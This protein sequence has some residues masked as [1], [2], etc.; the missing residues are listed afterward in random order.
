MNGATRPSSGL[1]RSVISYL[2]DAADYPYCALTSVKQMHGSDIIEIVVEPELDQ[3]RKI[4]ILH[5]EPVRV[6]FRSPDDKLSPIIVSMRK[7]FP[8]GHVHTSLERGID[9]PGLCI[10]EDNWHDLSSVM[11]GQV[12]IE[13]IRSWFTRM[14]IGNL[15]DTEQPAEPLI[16]SSAHT[17]VLPSGPF[18]DKLHLVAAHETAGVFTVFAGLNPPKNDNGIPQ[19]SLFKLTTEPQIHRAIAG[20]PS[21]LG[22]LEARLDEM[23]VDCK[24][25]LA[26]W[27]KHP[28]QMAVASTNCVLFIIAIPMRKA[29]GGDIDS[30]E[31]WAFTSDA[32]IAE[33]GTDLG[34]T[35]TSEASGTMR[36]TALLL[37]SPGTMPNVALDN[38]RVV[39]RLDRNAAR[40]FSGIQSSTDLELLAI[41][42]GAI[43]S[44]VVLGAAKSGLGRWTIVDGDIVLPH[45]T[46]RQVQDDQGIGFSKAD[47]LAYQANSL[48]AEAGHSSIIAD[49]LAPEENFADL[50]AA[51]QTADLAVDFSASPAVLGWM[52]D[53]PLKRAVSFFFGPDGRDLVLL[54][55]DGARQI[56]LDAIESQYFAA[57]ASDERLAGHLSAARVDKIR[58]ANACQDITRPL[59]TWQVQM[60]SALASGQLLELTKTADPSARIWR[61]D[62]ASGAV[63]VISISVAPI[64]RIVGQDWDI[65]VAEKVLHTICGLRGEALPDETGG[66]LLGTFDMVRRV[67]HVVEILPAP[68]DSRQ[69]PTHFVRG[70]KDLLPRIEAMAVNTAGRLSYIGEW[71]SHPDGAAAWPSSDDETVFSYLSENIGPTGAPYLMLICGSRESWVRGGWQEAD[72]V[73]GTIAH[74]T[75]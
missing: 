14:A 49:V 40:I 55:E 65:V 17:L 54:A 62:P 7:D 12:L 16:P 72:I 45:N 68:R 29:K 70:A 5:Q 38:W 58:Y 18:P 47:V 67:V 44:N 10:W 6:V 32:T 22:D 34:V 61:L 26:T 57:V 24:K 11:N 3:H 20:C 43:G 13:R 51:F 36:T 64:R 42:A 74:D 39:R 31:V 28:S 46:V 2:T 63:S 69:S 23:A 9:G 71:H 1:A 53:Q 56:P 8:H 41:G 73:E 21:N 19:F 50:D 66:V 59:P 15:H 35:D 48:L 30:H 4:A 27:L 37:S 60:L 33:I 25:E 75:T 52:A